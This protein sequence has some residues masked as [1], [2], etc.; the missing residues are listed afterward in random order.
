MPLDRE[1][2]DAIKAVVAAKDQPKSVA[3]RLTAWLEEMSQAELSRDDH[4]RHFDNL[5]DSIS[6]PEQLDAN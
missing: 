3:K 5:C 6:L 1:L 2:D 4:S